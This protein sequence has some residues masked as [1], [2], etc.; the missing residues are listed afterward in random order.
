MDRE[1]DI[2]ILGA[3][4]G[5]VTAL[6]AVRRELGP[7]LEWR[8]LTPAWQIKK[9]AR[10]DEK[11]ALLRRLE[12]QFDTARTECS[13]A[14]RARQAVEIVSPYR[15]SPPTPAAPAMARTSRDWAM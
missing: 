6:L 1:A 13:E 11:I 7:L 14:Y 10:L 3:R 12:K 2:R 4:D 15:R 8:R 9:I 5:L